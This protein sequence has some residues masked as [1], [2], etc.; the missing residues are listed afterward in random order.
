MTGLC[1]RLPVMP[2][3]VLERSDFCSKDSQVE[4]ST[5]YRHIRWSMVIIFSE[6]DDFRILMKEKRSGGCKV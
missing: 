4:G 1:L 3:A 2:A 6:S 5:Q